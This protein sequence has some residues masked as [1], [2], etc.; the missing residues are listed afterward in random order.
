MSQLPYAVVLTNPRLKDNPIV[1]VNR[2]FEALTGY[3]RASTIGRNCRFLQGV[4]TDAA[5]VHALRDAV[6]NERDATITLLNY[7]ADGSTFLNR[8]MISPLYDS[9]DNLTYFLGVQTIADEAEEANRLADQQMVA[10]RELQHRVK[11]HLSMVVSMIRMQARED[12]AEKD[13]GTLSRRVETLQ[14]LYEELTEDGHGRDEMIALGSYI[15]RV[16][17][18]LAHLDGRRGIRVNIDTDAIEVPFD[19]ATRIGLVVSE[20][21]TNALQHAFAGRDAGLVE[22]RLK[23]MSG[24][25]VRVQVVDDGVGLPT[26][27]DWPHKGSL[28]SRIVRQLVRGL[29]ADLSVQSE[30]SGTTVTFDVPADTVRP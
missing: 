2:Q 4:D 30:V 14:L 12:A 21:V 9:D 15:S 7:R 18:A 13:F 24:G 8:L 1:Y 3:S 6:R 23:E 5:S 16:G 22:L 26:H 25:T 17:N 10:L 29:G 19:V 28:G 20:I 27:I 11:N